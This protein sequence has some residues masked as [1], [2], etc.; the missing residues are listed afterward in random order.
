MLLSMVRTAVA[1]WAVILAW[2]AYPVGYLGM[3]AQRFYANRTRLVSPM[4]SA[5]DVI[6]NL[7][8]RGEL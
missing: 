3:I 4:A 7:R 6:A 5:R 2:A 1:P 8:T